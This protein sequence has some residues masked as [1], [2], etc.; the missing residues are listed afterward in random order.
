MVLEAPLRL[1]LLLSV[2]GGWLT[3]SACWFSTAKEDQ[4]EDKERK[5]ENVWREIQQVYKRQTQL[6]VL[7]FNFH[8]RYRV[9]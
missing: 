4:R 7:R 2:S 1:L 3:G 6:I 8:F 5:T 9:F